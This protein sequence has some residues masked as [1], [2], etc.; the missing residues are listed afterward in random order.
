MINKIFYL[1]IFL[2][3]LIVSIKKF[4]LKNKL[5][6]PLKKH[7][8]FQII[9]TIIFLVSIYMLSY[10][11][12]ANLTRTLYFW[13][14]FSSYLILVFFTNFKGE[15]TLSFLKLNTKT[16]ILLLSLL[17][18]FLNVKPLAFPRHGT[19][20]EAMNTQ[21]YNYKNIGDKIQ[22]RNQSL[23]TEF[24]PIR[25]L[26]L[27]NKENIDEFQKIFDEISLTECLLLNKA[28]KVKF[29]IFAGGYSI[30][31]YENNYISVKKGDINHEHKVV[32]KVNDN[33]NIISKVHSII[34][35][36]LLTLE[37]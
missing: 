13:I 12:N 30:Y 10:F 1:F 28:K 33:Y 31:V 8:Y 34:K 26:K 29:D 22:I 36:E 37:K 16:I 27:K 35:K 21:K 14:L 7:I 3:L 9:T 2:L 20:Y 18:F 19:I 6:K 11:M 24:M 23:D 15:F 5:A 4:E 25:I 32:F 17:F